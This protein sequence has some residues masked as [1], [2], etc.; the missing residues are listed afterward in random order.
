MAK[1]ADFG[2]QPDIS[3]DEWTGTTH[4]MAPEFAALRQLAEDDAPIPQDAH[5]LVSR[6]ADVFSFG[7][8]LWEIMSFG[9]A[10]YGAYKASEIKAE[11]SAGKRLERSMHYRPTRV[12]S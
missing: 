6:P 11:V 4:Y 12:P 2:W 9:R 7:V 10:P 5:K 8:M 1:V 3:P